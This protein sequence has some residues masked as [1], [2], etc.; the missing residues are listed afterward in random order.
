MSASASTSTVGGQITFSGSVAPDK[1]GHVIY[2]QR[3]GADG[4]WHTVEVRIVHPGSVF[5]F[6]WTFGAEGTKQFRA[7]IFGGPVNVGAASAPVTVQV[8]QP[9]VT[10]L[11]SAG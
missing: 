6:G 11:P 3:L 7:R 9:P 2:L 5:Q 10:S 4:D 8:T 1:S